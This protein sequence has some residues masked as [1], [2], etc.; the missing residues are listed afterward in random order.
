MYVSAAADGYQVVYMTN[1]KLLYVFQHL[2]DVLPLVE[3]CCQPGRRISIS[4]FWYNIDFAISDTAENMISSIINKSVS[5]PF[6][7]QWS[8]MNHNNTVY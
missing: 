5:R 4:A 3:H 2:Q 7:I 8:L 6:T 1:C